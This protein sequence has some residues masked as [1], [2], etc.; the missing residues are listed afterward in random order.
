MS[1]TRLLVLGVVRGYGRVHGYRVGADLLSWG[2]G[3][4]ANVKWGSIYH[5]LRQATRAGFLRDHDDVPGRTDYELTERGEAEFRRLL[6]DALRQP[7]PRPDL[8]AAALAMLPALPRAEALDLL[9]ERL[10]ALEQ[11]RE[12]AQAQLDGVDRPAA[13]AGAVRAV[14]GDRRDRAQWTRGLIDRLSDGRLP[15]G[16]RAGVAGPA[17]QLAGPRRRSTSSLSTVVGVTASRRD[18]DARE[19]RA[20]PLAQAGQRRRCSSPDGS[21]WAGPARCPSSSCPAARPASCAAPR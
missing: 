19:D 2:A 12:K 8:I 6:R 5:A 21:A 15:D 4:W 17:G 10:T 13:R 7:Q 16:R 20:A 9:R 1:A 11:R 3:E 18:P 14:G